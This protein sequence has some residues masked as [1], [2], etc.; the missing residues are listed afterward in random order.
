M[1]AT[2][3]CSASSVGPVSCSLAKG[4]EMEQCSLPA[5]HTDEKGNRW[6]IVWNNSCKKLLQGPAQEWTDVGSVDQWK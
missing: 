2:P 4:G 1:L 3:A 6:S 5:H